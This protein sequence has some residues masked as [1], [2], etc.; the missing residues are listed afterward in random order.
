MLTPTTRMLWQLLLL[1]PVGQSSHVQRRI[2]YLGC[3][4]ARLFRPAYRAQRESISCHIFLRL[5][6]VELMCYTFSLVYFFVKPPPLEYSV[7]ITRSKKKD[8]ISFTSAGGIELLWKCQ[9]I[10]DKSDNQRGDIE[11]VTVSC[12]PPIKPQ[13]TS[14]TWLTPKLCNTYMYPQHPPPPPSYTI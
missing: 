6:D 10:R 12:C 13:Q 7:C 5:C 3:T 2:V 8:V 1:S 11:S 9:S 14:V 4:D